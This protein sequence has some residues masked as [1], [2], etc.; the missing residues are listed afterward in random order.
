MGNE[1]APAVAV[2]EDGRLVGLVDRATIL[3]RVH[4]GQR[5]AGVHREPRAAA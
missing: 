4:F 5:R 2:V 3:R 1:G